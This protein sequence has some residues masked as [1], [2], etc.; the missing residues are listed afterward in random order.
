M[1]EFIISKVDENDKILNEIDC[2][3]FNTGVVSGEYGI[4][5]SFNDKI[6]FFKLLNP[7]NN[8]LKKFV[9]KEI[10][11]FK[12]LYQVEKNKIDKSIINAETKYILE[13]KKVEE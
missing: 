7:K 9:N 4:A 2:M 8:K 10:K 5:N 13:N 12:T 3:L 6:L 1:V 11:R